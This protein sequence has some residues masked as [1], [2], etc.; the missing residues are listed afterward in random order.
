MKCVHTRPCLSDVCMH[1]YRYIC[2]YICR[3]QNVY[4]CNICRHLDVYML[5]SPVPAPTFLG[6]GAETGDWRV[7]SPAI[8]HRYLQRNIICN[9]ICFGKAKDERIP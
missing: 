5:Q 4:I 3:H 8:D 9:M 6:G 2:I 7:Q 1:E